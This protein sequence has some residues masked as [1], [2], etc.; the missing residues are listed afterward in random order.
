MSQAIFPTAWS[1]PVAGRRL[2]AV[3]A[4]VFLAAHFQITLTAM[5]RRFEPVEPDDAYSYIVKAEQM[6]ADVFQRGPAW[7]DL[8]RQVYRPDP[9][10]Q[11]IYGLNRLEHRLFYV[12]HPLHSAALAGL[13]AA[14]LDWVQAYR[15][16]QL[17]GVF[18]IGGGVAAWL[19]ALYGPGPAGLALLLLAPALF[20]RQGID[21]PVPSNMCMGLALAVWAMAWRRSRWVDAAL[22]VCAAVMTVLHPAGKVYSVIAAVFYAMGRRA[23]RRREAVALSAA[24]AVLAL[25]VFA[26][27]VI[28][29]PLLRPQTPDGPPGF[30]WSQGVRANL[31]TLGNY[32][33]SSFDPFR[34][35]LWIPA[36]AL[37]A[38]AV[39]SAVRVGERRRRIASTAAA[40]ALLL[41]AGIVYVMPFYPG[42]VVERFFVPVAIF[43]AGA[44][45]AMLWDSAVTFAR[46]AMAM[47]RV[48][49]RRHGGSGPIRAL[50][51]MRLRFALAGLCVV[52]VTAFAAVFGAQWARQ[53]G[54][55][56]RA[57]IAAYP[58][59]LD[60]AQTRRLLERSTPA[61]RV[62]Y[63]QETVLYFYLSN[64]AHGRGA[65]FC[66]P[67]SMRTDDEQRLR[68]D[69]SLRFAAQLHPRHLLPQATPDGLL[70]QPGQSLVIQFPSPGRRLGGLGIGVASA[71]SGA[72]MI[73]ECA[74]GEGRN[75]AADLDVGPQAGGISW[76]EIPEALADVSAESLKIRVPSGAPPLELRGLR[77]KPGQTLLW[78]W[79]E[80]VIVG[81]GD[82][83]EPSVAVPLDCGWLRRITGRP[84]RVLDDTGSTVLLEI[85]PIADA[86][87]RRASEPDDPLGLD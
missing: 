83:F 60:A 86:A 61:D 48:R 74:D 6:R 42:A 81:T 84:A 50:R 43:L 13:R 85:A 17:A 16:V 24:A 80:G 59:R 33:L 67:E 26:G 39:V 5:L 10:P 7:E 66:P 63:Y 77:T 2:F 23:L 69:G 38:V 21:H 14:G 28:D 51:R 9:D 22:P 37:A 1:I 76:R 15:A 87:P 52:C 68:E 75:R 8:R 29:R 82:G 45:G 47:R 64:G 3:G 32:I 58:Y 18:L 12:Y 62:L 30:A 57:T 46:G 31:D 79:D 25:A 11:L 34:T 70:I 56:L 19:C 41:S 72:R 36:V 55:L 44:V 73:L 27:R 71:G 35:G 49:S 78:P 40:L 54:I 53:R 65:F 4:G 20:R